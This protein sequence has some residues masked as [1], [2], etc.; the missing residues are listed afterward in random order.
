MSAYPRLNAAGCISAQYAVTGRGKCSGSRS[1]DPG[2]GGSKT[3][4]MAKVSIEGPFST[5]ETFS[6]E[7]A[8]R[9][10]KSR[11]STGRRRWLPLARSGHGPS[12]VAAVTV[13]EGARVRTPRLG[14][15]GASQRHVDVA[16]R[17]VP[18]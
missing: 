6:V 10:H 2:P 12:C 18:E 4:D 16:I 13:R 15:P 17:A 14:R 1:Q 7:L 9:A 8:Q 11:R 3:G 5:R